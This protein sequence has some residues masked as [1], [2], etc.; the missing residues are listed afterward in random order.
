M[1]WHPES[2]DLNPIE[3]VW[4]LMDSKIVKRKKCP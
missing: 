4:D 1:V 3:K 2:F